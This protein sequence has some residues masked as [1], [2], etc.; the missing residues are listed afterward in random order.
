MLRYAIFG[1]F[2]GHLG[3]MQ[4]RR[5]CRGLKIGHPSFSDNLDP[6]EHKSA[7]KINFGKLAHRRPIFYH[8]DLH[9]NPTWW[10][11]REGTYPDCGPSHLQRINTKPGS[12]HSLSFDQISPHHPLYIEQKPRE[13]TIL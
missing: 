4:I 10:L 1:I 3:F 11:P 6:K 7:K 2:G 13:S 8:K 9:Y 5:G 12:K